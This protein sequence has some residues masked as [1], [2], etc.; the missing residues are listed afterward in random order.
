MTR[1]GTRGEGCSLNR[2]IPVQEDQNISE[3]TAI[4]GIEEYRPSER[5][6]HRSIEANLGVI[7]GHVSWH[8]EGQRSPRFGEQEGRS[9]G[10]GS[11]LGKAARESENSENKWGT[12]GGWGKPKSSG[13]NPTLILK[14]WR[15]L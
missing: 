14:S 15:E 6:G 2:Q 8:P 9:G 5:W 7:R 1:A 3:S 12:S 10:M 13:K 11:L 4:G